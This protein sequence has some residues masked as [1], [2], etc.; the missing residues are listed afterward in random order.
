ASTT[1]DDPAY[2]STSREAV[3]GTGDGTCLPTTV[4]PAH[5]REQQ[6]IVGTAPVS[7][8]VAR[9][10]VIRIND[11]GL[12]AMPGEPTIQMGRR[13]E[14][15]VK[16]AAN[17]ASRVHRGSDIFRD[18]FTVG[19]A[20]DY[21]SYMATTQEYENYDYEGSFSLFGQQT[22]NALKQRLAHLGALLASETPVEPC[23][24]ER[25]CI[26]PPPTTELAVKP[27]ATTPDV[28]A[29]T[30]QSQPADVQRFTGTSFSWIGGGP[31]AEW[32]QND[33]MVELQ[34]Q[35]GATW[36]TVASDL[37]STVP[38]HYDKC[39]AENHWTA[40]TDPTV[41]AQPG[42]YRFHVTGHSALAPTQVTPYTLDSAPFDVKPYTYLTVVK[43]GDGVFHVGNP[44]PDALANYRYRPR[45][46][47][48]ATVAGLGATFTVPVGQT[49]TIA[50]GQITDA[51]GNTNTQTITVSSTG[52]TATP[53][54]DAPA[55][56]SPQLVCAS[57]G[58]PNASVP[59]APWTPGF[60]LLAMLVAGFTLRRARRAS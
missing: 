7:P 27:V 38:L 22:G 2:R 51:Y 20:N 25:N 1:A 34:R 21:M 6:L 3:L 31:S 30:T 43:D 41:D 8:H 4:Y 60:L 13:V 18:V 55:P 5:H 10:Q 12:A 42:T 36:Q 32:L 45:Y 54:H 39:G 26:Q 14:R 17:A 46:D 50:P 59:E 37:D 16:A 35:N 58:Q 40:Y 53:A 9:V 47:A 24:L 33:P 19:L 11:I 52:A 44:A 28:L 23:T 48:T 57:A 56:A 29:A 15:S 49:R